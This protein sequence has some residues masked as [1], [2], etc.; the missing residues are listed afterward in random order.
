MVSPPFSTSPHHCARL[1]ATHL[2]VQKMLSSS[3]LRPPPALK[4]ST[5][6]TI[7]STILPELSLCLRSLPYCI[8]GQAFPGW[9]TI[10]TEYPRTLLRDIIVPDEATAQRLLL[11][12]RTHGQHVKQLVTLPIDD[13]PILS[14]GRVIDACSNLVRFTRDPQCVAK[15]NLVFP[16]L[17]WDLTGL[18]RSDWC[19]SDCSDLCCFRRIVNN[20]RNLRHLTI[21]AGLLLRTDLFDHSFTL[22]SSVET[23]SPYSAESV[24]E[25]TKRKRTAPDD[26]LINRVVVTDMT[27]IPD[28]F[29]AKITELQISP[30]W[31]PNAG[32]VALLHPQPSHYWEPRSSLIYSVAS[33]AP[34]TL[35]PCSFVNTLGSTN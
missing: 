12:L 20:T 4:T 21:L 17:W 6:T 11:L 26:S 10:A 29:V 13:E 19:I 18:A 14:L 23:N 24:D 15:V 28:C 31:Y 30:W 3:P 9:T 25:W 5:S 2:Q 35:S 34:L 16:K 32:L 33:S 27:P 7:P 22:P 1:L 8:T